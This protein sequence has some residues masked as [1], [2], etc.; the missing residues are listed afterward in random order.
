MFVLY[1]GITILTLSYFYKKY[2]RHM[3]FKKINDRFPRKN[4]YEFDLSIYDVSL[5]F[6]FTKN[7][8]DRCILLVSGYRDTPFLWNKFSEK[9]NNHG[10]DYYAPRTHSKGRS[11]FQYTSYKDWILTYFE[12]LCM[13]QHQYHNV[14]I[15]ALSAGSFIALY[16]SQFEYKCKIN[17]VFLCSPYLC[18]KNDLF[19]NFFYKSAL[20]PFLNPVIN[21]FIDIFFKF[22]LKSADNTFNCVRNI[23]DKDN[24]DDDYYEFATCCYMD[25]E[26]LKMLRLKI[27]AVKIYGKIVILYNKHDEVIPKISKQVNYL[28]T[29]NIY[30]KANDEIGIETI[31]I[32]SKKSITDKCGHVMFKET[33]AVLSNIEEH[34]FNK[35]DYFYKKINN[36]EY[37]SLLSNSYSSK[38]LTNNIF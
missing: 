18:V 22:K 16:I 38:N 32:P 23:H 25:N 12:M 29:N 33:D 27:D 20:S 14:D 5:P 6:S 35:L 34:I 37:Q 21:T 26:V 11:Y 15:I 36:D 1:S 4:K 28:Y 10:V 7:K 3:A 9:L 2:C 30:T 24:L 19:Y 13:L 8:K 31:N 17:N